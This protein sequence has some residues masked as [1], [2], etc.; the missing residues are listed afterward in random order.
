M[1]TLSVSSYRRRCSG[2]AYVYVRKTTAASADEGDVQAGSGDVRCSLRA[3]G[4]PD[5][6]SRIRA[7]CTDVESHVIDSGRK[8]GIC[9]TLAILE[10]SCCIER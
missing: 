7:V 6:E 3:F 4:L 2:V 9:E 1:G 8:R 10:Y 5:A